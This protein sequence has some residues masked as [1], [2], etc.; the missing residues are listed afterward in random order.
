[1]TARLVDLY[2]NE[3]RLII[4]GA[5]RINTSCGTISLWNTSYAFNPQHQIQIIISGSNYPRFDVWKESGEIK[6]SSKS[7]VS[8]PKV[9][10]PKVL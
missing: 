7:Y 10:L 5:L 3:S 1:M 8:L 9:S 2:K 4:D 6:I